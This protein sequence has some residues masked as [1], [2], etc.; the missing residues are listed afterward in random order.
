MLFAKL[1]FLPMRNQSSYMARSLKPKNR[2]L[3]QNL[4]MK[5]RLIAAIVICLI[6][7]TPFSGKAQK[8][9]VTKNG[10]KYHLASCRYAATGATATDVK[11]ALAKKFVACDV[12]KPPAKPNSEGTQCTA[13]TKDGTRCSRLTSSKN[14]KCWQ[15]A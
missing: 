11:D 1:L 13:K 7:C 14:G 9:M 6:C 15:H 2:Y 5:I 4:I 12:C 8:V 3:L 10:D